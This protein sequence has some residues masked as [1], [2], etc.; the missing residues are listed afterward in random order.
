MLT[1][2]TVSKQF[3]SVTAYMCISKMVYIIVCKIIFPYY[4]NPN[5]KKYLQVFYLIT[6]QFWRY[7]SLTHIITYKY[8]KTIKLKPL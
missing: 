4:L 2:C 5:L 3:L 6:W 7:I 1:K 8:F